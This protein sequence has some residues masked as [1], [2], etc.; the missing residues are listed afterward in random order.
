MILNTWE[1]V[2]PVRTSTFS[3]TFWYCERM[4]EN[5]LEVV[6]Y[7]FASGSVSP[8]VCSTA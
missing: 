7:I 2:R 1:G 5:S 8:V 4:V 3:T 6:V